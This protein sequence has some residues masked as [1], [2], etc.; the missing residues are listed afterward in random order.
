MF[1]KG[2]KEKKRGRFSNVREMTDTQ[3]CR[4]GGVNAESWRPLNVPINWS[5][6]WMMTENIAKWIVKT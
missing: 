4:V 6:D 5:I 3:Y 2:K 1:Q